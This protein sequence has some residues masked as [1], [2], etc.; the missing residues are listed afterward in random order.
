MTFQNRGHRL[1]KPIINPLLYFKKFG[2]IDKPVDPSA[3]CKICGSFFDLQL[4][5]IYKRLKVQKYNY[6][7][8][9]KSNIGG[10][11]VVLCECCHI[12]VHQDKLVV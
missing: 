5:R 11:V 2:N 3:F 10:R 6:M 7:S 9:I 8:C 12:L 4:H 1:K